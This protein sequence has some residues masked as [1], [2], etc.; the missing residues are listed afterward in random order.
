MISILVAT[1]RWERCWDEVTTCSNRCR[2]ERRRKKELSSLAA[3]AAVGATAHKTSQ[4]E[5]VGTESTVVP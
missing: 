1:A 2:S 4:S 3:G 5:E